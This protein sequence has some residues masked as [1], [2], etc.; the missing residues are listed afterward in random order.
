[1]EDGATVRLRRSRFRQERDMSCNMFSVWPLADGR[2]TAVI[3]SLSHFSDGPGQYIGLLTNGNMPKP[4]STYD[5]N[6][7]L[8]ETTMAEAETGQ[9]VR[10]EEVSAQIYCMLLN[11]R[12][13]CLHSR[14]STM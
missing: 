1:M 5:R 9:K 3:Q 4:G 14:Y 8:A 13:V 11:F 7:N 2:K 10:L 6:R 12:L